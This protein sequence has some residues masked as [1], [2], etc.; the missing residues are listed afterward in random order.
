[1]QGPGETF[2]ISVEIDQPAPT[3]TEIAI[4]IDGMDVGSIVVDTG[5]T[6]SGGDVAA[7]HLGLAPGQHEF[8]ATLGAVTLTAMLTILTPP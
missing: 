3:P 7:D 4:T 2:T 8:T 5:E 1:M 6:M